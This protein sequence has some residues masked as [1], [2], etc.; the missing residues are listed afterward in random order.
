MTFAKSVYIIDDDPIIVFGLRKLLSQIGF[1]GG[2]TPFGNGKTALDDI[3]R[4]LS[5][6]KRMPDVI[7]LDINMPVMDGWQFLEAFINIPMDQTIRVN[8]VTSSID[9]ADRYKAAR[10]QSQTDHPISYNNKPIKK[11]EI[12]EIMEVA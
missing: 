9:P 11:K 5:L 2:I 3:E 12:Q 10:F 4:S 1:S 6:K 8:I 7:F